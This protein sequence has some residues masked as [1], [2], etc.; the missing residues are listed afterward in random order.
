MGTRIETVDIKINISIGY[1]FSNKDLSISNDSHESV[2]MFF[3][4]FLIS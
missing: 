3:A 2:Y 4:A 1:L